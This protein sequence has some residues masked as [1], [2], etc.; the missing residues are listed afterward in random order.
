MKIVG[1]ALNSVGGKE[2]NRHPMLRLILPP[3]PAAQ[4][5]S[6]IRD[7]RTVRE[8]NVLCDEVQKR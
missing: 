5:Q 3:S 8:M 7:S 1:K 4:E 2:D 6:R